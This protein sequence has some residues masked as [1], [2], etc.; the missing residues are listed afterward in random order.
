MTT[1]AIRYTDEKYMSIEELRVILPI[2]G[3]DAVWR[4]IE[5]YRK[6]FQI[7]YEMNN[8]KI[9]LT[10]T[11]SLFQKTVKVQLLLHQFEKQQSISYLMNDVPADFLMMD[12]KISSKEL[13]KFNEALALTQAFLFYLL[14]NNQ[15]KTVLIFN[16]FGYS[17][18]ASIFMEMMESMV[19]NSHF[20]MD[21]TRTYHEMLEQLSS[22]VQKQMLADKRENT[23]LEAVFDELVQLYPYVNP[24]AIA[25]FVEHRKKHHYYTVEDYRN[26]T[27]CSYE[28]ARSALNSL[29]AVGWY[30]K[31]KI[32]KKYCYALKAGIV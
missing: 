20:G 27:H 7:I 8:Q 28:T 25:Y 9:A 5:A 3:F 2:Q 30:E 18:S 1:L 10:M 29:C 12:E 4:E 32:G 17:A 31:H 23:L 14:T 21:M 15:S 22:L 13:N 6:A 11:P 26:F 24:K 19:F 16:C